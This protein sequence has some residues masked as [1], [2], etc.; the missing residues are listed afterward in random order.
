MGLMLFDLG[1]F[2]QAGLTLAPYTKLFL[3]PGVKFIRPP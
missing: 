3:P 1:S 2:R